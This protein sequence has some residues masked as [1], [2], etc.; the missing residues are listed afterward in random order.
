MKKF[1]RL[2]LAVCSIVFALSC[3][4]CEGIEDLFEEQQ[5]IENYKTDIVGYWQLSGKREFWRFDKFGTGTVLVGEVNHSVG[6]GENWDEADDSYEGEDG[7]NKFRWYLEQTGLEILYKSETSEVYYPEPDAPY[8]IE[9]L[10][11]DSLIWRTNNG[12]GR[13]QILLKTTK[14]R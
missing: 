11:S 8:I 13:R 7:T 12:A 1:Q 3:V 5:N 14:N 10:T 9:R 4:S 2:L 6:N